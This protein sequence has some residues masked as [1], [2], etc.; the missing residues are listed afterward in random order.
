MKILE[1]DKVCIRDLLGKDDFKIW[2]NL[3]FVNHMAPIFVDGDVASVY[4]FILILTEVPEL[5]FVY[6]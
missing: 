6:K 4:E 5:T 1:T 2:R 3:D